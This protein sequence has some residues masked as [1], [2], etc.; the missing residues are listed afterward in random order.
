LSNSEIVVKIPAGP[1]YGELKFA[2]WW[3]ELRSDPRFEPLMV[4]AAKPI[5]LQ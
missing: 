4:E 3:D 2:P 5:P 1:S